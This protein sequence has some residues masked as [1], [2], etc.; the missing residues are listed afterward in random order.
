[1][2]MG[3][4]WLKQRLFPVRGPGMRPSD[5]PS[6]L[7]MFTTVGYCDKQGMPRLLEDLAALMKR[8]INQQA[9][10]DLGTMV[11][12][13]E[14]YTRT[15]IVGWFELPPILSAWR[16]NDASFTAPLRTRL[17]N[18]HIYDEQ[19]R[20]EVEECSGPTGLIL[21]DPVSM[22]VWARGHWTLS[23]L[24]VNYLLTGM[25]SFVDIP[26]GILNEK[27][28]EDLHR[29]WTNASPQRGKMLRDWMQ[30]ASA[31]VVQNL[32]REARGH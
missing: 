30:S 5:L 28:T 25:G 17:G 12:K 10:F 19:D 24:T 20:R 9:E 8:Q 15:Q 29:A 7:P 23:K 31:H 6:P 21:R 4:S 22:P 11:S 26:H 16:L 14:E 2:E 3:A 27:L 18:L 32:P 1:M 13:A